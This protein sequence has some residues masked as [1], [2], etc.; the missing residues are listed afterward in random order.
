MFK[1][2]KKS[3]IK[4]NP[5]IIKENIIKI[6]KEFQFNTLI[7]ANSFIIFINNGTPPNEK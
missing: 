7:K 3:S 5:C 1:S 4:E 2:F 6:I